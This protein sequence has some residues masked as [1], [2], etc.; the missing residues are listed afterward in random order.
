MLL[1]MALFSSFSS[2]FFLRFNFIY[3]CLR[4]VFV[5][6]RGLSLVGTSRGFSCCGARALG[7]RA[8]V[9]VARGLQSTGSAV[10]VHGPS[11]S[12]ACGLFPDQGSNPCP[13][14]WQVDSYPLCHQGSPY[15]ILFYG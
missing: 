13:L 5:A 6:V 8:P 11:C 2:F 15:F 10:V 4:W 9:V 1:Q 14:N 3:F 12:A 7:M